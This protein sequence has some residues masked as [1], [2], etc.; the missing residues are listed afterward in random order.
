MKNE[1]KLFIV[2]VLITATSS[3]C[4]FYV[5]DWIY[6]RCNAPH[7]IVYINSFYTDPLREIPE[8]PEENMDR[9]LASFTVSP[10]DFGY[11]E[12]NGSFEEYVKKCADDTLSFYIFH[13][14]T[15]S[16]YSWDDIRELK[17]ILVRYDLGANDFSK[18]PL[19]RNGDRSLLY[20]PTE[21]MRAIHMYPPYDQVMA[22]YEADC[23]KTAAME[24]N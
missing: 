10:D 9:F 23:K 13:A 6:I 17:K 8:I 15:V 7:N 21:S 20:P 2:C 22:Q 12:V 4:A 18:L 1:F 19:D 3:R 11:F 14:D 5:T 24:E 16:R